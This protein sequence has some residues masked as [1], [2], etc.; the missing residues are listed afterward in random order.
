MCRWIKSMQYTPAGGFGE[1][2]LER[3]AGS[4]LGI[5]TAAATL[6]ALTLCAHSKTG[7]IS[8][9]VNRAIPGSRRDSMGQTN[10]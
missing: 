5:A 7:D 2:E 4:D 8:G 9:S 10:Q 6:D 3:G 1:M